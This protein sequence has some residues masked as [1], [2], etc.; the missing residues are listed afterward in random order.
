MIMEMLG[1]ERFKGMGS[2]NAEAT[3]KRDGLGQDEILQ[4]DRN[5]PTIPK[6]DKPVALVLQATIRLRNLDLVCYLCQER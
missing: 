4:E 1:G 5:Q 6:A 3:G 2:S